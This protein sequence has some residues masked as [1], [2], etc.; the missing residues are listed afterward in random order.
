MKYLNLF[1]SGAY[2]FIILF[3]SVSVSLCPVSPSI[4]GDHAMYM[5][6]YMYA[7]THV[8]ICIIYMTG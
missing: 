8:Y 1:K 5:P 3:L 6:T 2:Y 7:Q 4:Y